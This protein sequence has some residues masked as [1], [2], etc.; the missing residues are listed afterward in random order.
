M[1]ATKKTVKLKN[2]RGNSSDFTFE[3]A[4]NLLRL[5]NKK[6]TKGWS[7]NEKNW[8]FEN[9]EISRKPNKAVSKESE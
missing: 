7:L 5:Q 6:G 2:Q 8:I 9:N 4:L 3:H 1:A